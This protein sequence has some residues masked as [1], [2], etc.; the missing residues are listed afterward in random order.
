[1]TYQIIITE[2]V[3]NVAVTSQ[4][5]P[6]VI[7]YNATNINSG[8]T[9]GDANVATFLAGFGSNT[10]STTGNITGGYFVGNG[11][12]LTGIASSYGNANVVANLAALG[13]NPISTTGN[14]T[15]GYVIGNGSAL[16]AITGA[17]VSGT[18]ANATFATSAASA[19]TATTATT[20]NSVAGANVTGTVANATFATSAGT[21]TTATTAGTVT[22][23]AQANITSVGVLTSLSSTGNITGANV[24]GTHFGSGAA[25][26]SI[27]GANVTG[28]VANAT[29]ATSAGSAT[30]A[31]TADTANSVA[32]ANVTGTVANATFA[33]SAGSATTATTAGTV[34]TNAQ[35]NITSTGTLSALSVSGN[36]TSGN[37]ITPGTISAT[38]NITTAGYF[39]GNFAGNITGNLTVP[40]ANTDVL[41]NNQGN[42]GASTN[43]TFN[44]ATN[45]M[46]VT[47]SATVTGNITGGNVGTAGN[48]TGAYIFGNGSQLSA[49][50]G[51]N[52]TGTVANATY[53]LNANAATYATDAVQANTANTANSVAGANVSGTVANA[54]Y[55]LNSN[56]AT[57]ASVAT[58]ADTANSVAGANVSGTVANATFA[59]SAGSATT[60][61]TA[62]TV[63][64]GA[65]A[66]ITSLGT[67]TSL[68]VSG[69]TTTGNLLTAGV[70]SATG[71]VTGSYIFGN[72]SQLTGLPAGYSNANATTLL[73]AFGSNTISTT[74]NITS[75]NLNVTVDAVITGNL[76]VNGTTTTVNSNTVTINDKF[77]N[78]AN[79]APTAAAAN[80]GGLGVGPVGGEYATLT[81]N[82]TNNDW[83][84]NIALSVNGNVTAG[85]FV[86]SGAALSAITG[87]NVTG[88]V[89]NATFATSAGSANT[90]NTATFAGTANAVA[91]ANVS[92]T[93]ANATFATSAGTATTAATVTDAAQPNIT[94]VGI[95]TAVNTSGAVS[96]TGNITGNYFLGNGSQLTGLP[97]QPGTYGNANVVANVA[98]LGSNPVS[99]TGNITAGYVIGNGSLLSSITGANVSGTVANATFATSAGSATT[100]TTATFAGTANAVAGAN[101][102]GTVANAT[103]ATSAGS[104]TTSTFADTANAV[105]GANVSGTVA[106][107]TFATT[108]GSATTANTV[109]DATQANITSVGTLTSLSVS[110]NITSSGNISGNYILGDGSQLTG[111]TSTYGNA[112]VSNFLA[113]GFGSNNI[114][115]TGN[116]TSGNSTVSNTLNVSNITGAAGQTVTITAE[117]TNDIHL[118]AD[119]IRIGDNNNPA[120]LVTHGTGNLILRTHEGAANQGNITLVNGANG[121]IQLNPNGTGLVTTTAISATGNVSGSYIIGNGSLLSA[122]TGANVTGTVA[123]ATF[124]TSAGTATSATTANTVTDAAQANITSVGTLTSVSVTGN[125][126]I[127]GNINMPTAD[128]NITLGLVAIRN[129]NNRFYVN[130]DTDI[131]GRLS[132]SGNVTGNYILGNGS[133][134]T[135]LPAGYSNADVTTLLAS[136]GSNTIST[137]GNIT[138]GNLVGIGSLTSL[139]VTGN[140]NVSGNINL[141]TADANITFG[142]VAIRNYNNRFYVNTDTDIAGQ[143]SASGNV[144]GGNLLTTGLASVTGNLTAG[145]IITSGSTIN[146][147]NAFAYS[148]ANTLLSL[149]TGRIVIGNGYDGNTA[150]QYDPSNA[151]R[152]SRLSVQDKVTYDY[153]ANS[154]QPGSRLLTSYHWADLAGSTISAASSTRLSSAAFVMNVGNG[155]SASSATTAMQAIQAA[156]LVGNASSSTFGNVGNIGNATVNY[157]TAQGSF[158][159]VYAGSTANTAIGTL[160]NPLVA[161]SG[162]NIGNSLGFAYARNDFTNNVGGL[163]AWSIGFFH[164][165]NTASFGLQMAGN[166]RLSSNYYAFYNKDNYADVQ[167]GSLRSFHYFTSNV[168]ATGGSQAISKA[169]GPYQT[170]TGNLTANLDVTSFTNFATSNT[171]TAGTNTGTK[172]SSDVVTL[173]IP[174][175]ATPY[176]INMPTGNTQ[177]KYVGNIS[178]V[179]GPA[180]SITQVQITGSNVG[181][182]VQYLVN[183]ENS[184]SNILT[185]G[186]ISATGNITGGNVISLARSQAVNFSETVTAFGNATGTITPNISLG[187]IQ[188]MTLT[189]NITLNAITNI[190]TGQSMTLI[191]TQDGTGG[192]TLT[193]TMKFAGNSRTL[194]TAAAATDI[195]SV[196]YDGTNYWSS[197]TKGYA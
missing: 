14:I 164:P 51:A 55:A 131:A 66:N 15:A 144:I 99:T 64:D 102:S 91:G 87:A 173:M 80:G 37:L 108:A 35:P 79:N 150:V 23:A 188:T 126:N 44:S 6:I 32:G 179:T 133:Q 151:T 140:A 182:T 109:T 76:T 84:T 101:V 115:T 36:T 121:N 123:N 48:V 111:I 122:L 2:E 62:N 40:G 138:A 97:V 159:N 21:A 100:A 86:G 166:V 43:F 13:S 46:N 142:L 45:V 77:I 192:R 98:A 194:S 104:S 106:N 71:N 34:T 42:A 196:F 167:L 56:A 1:M 68:S 63:T 149:N 162:G 153:T 61:V 105:A 177:I 30:T 7:E 117:G 4:S 160:A 28:T 176:S 47:G 19:T 184:G 74:G 195:I 169:N 152:G 38:G 165:D 70:V 24:T 29:F 168:L 132:A 50:S 94:S 161:S 137:T 110:G 81:Y 148:P 186:L 17:N 18:V 92:G 136:F 154:L 59:T 125:A 93:V 134:L 72:G 172:L 124:A 26:S 130:T 181:G 67:L 145:N 65:Q 9:Y 112:N 128:A 158:V 185:D 90:A 197:L 27:T 190:A 85:N 157:A 163:S 20:A 22:T 88:T 113:N 89:A 95:L 171:V 156:V 119:S 183:M 75:G 116:V 146:N 143:L 8:S 78:V 33:T 73:A 31:T 178:T 11:S 170:T 193:S 16:S 3:A 118:D 57:F 107:A 175:G 12:Q 96:A 174:M 187:A 10:V 69:N 52:V 135:G 58:F 191:L 83:N 25:L 147:T 103:F 39:V 155:N 53:A 127:S 120:T 60:A 54:T 180:N 114:S 82:S 49:L 139:S 141:P 129:Y 189:G 41:F 5:Y